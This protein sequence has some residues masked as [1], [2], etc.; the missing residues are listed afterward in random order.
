MR[1][2]EA[3]R[4]NQEMVEAGIREAEESYRTKLALREEDQEAYEAEEHLIQTGS[5]EQ[6]AKR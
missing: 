1:G 3:C 4:A 2:G 5:P 6:K